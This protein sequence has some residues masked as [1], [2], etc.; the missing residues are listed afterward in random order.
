MKETFETPS[1]EIIV[2]EGKGIYTDAID[3]SHQY[4]GEPDPI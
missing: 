2:M 4:G 1:M 3:E